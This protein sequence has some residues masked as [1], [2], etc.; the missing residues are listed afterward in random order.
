MKQNAAIA[1]D[2]DRVCGRIFDSAAGGG[3]LAAA[4]YGTQLSVCS[5]ISFIVKLSNQ[6]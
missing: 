6:A 5:K 4:A 2:T 3:T 1:G